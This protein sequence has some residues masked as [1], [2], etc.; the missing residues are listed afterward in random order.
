MSLGSGS[1]DQ[2]TANGE[3]AGGSRPS[4]NESGSVRPARDGDGP[5]SLNTYGI[6]P[7]TVPPFVLDS[8]FEKVATRGFTA[9]SK[10]KV[11]DYNRFKLRDPFLVAYDGKWGHFASNVGTN[12]AYANQQQMRVVDQSSSSSNNS[13][14]DKQSLSDDVSQAERE[15][16]RQEILKDLNSEWGG[17]KRLEELFNTPIAGNYEFKSSED[18]KAWT[19]YV[20]RI[21]QYYYGK[22]T[23]WDPSTNRTEL[24]Q[25][26]RASDGRRN[27]DW[28]EELN[29]DKLRF[30]RFKQRKLQ[31]WMPELNALLL[32]NQYLPLGLRIVVG[33]LSLISLGLAVRIYQNS[34]S[35]IQSIDSTIDQQP[36]TIMAICVNTIA[37]VYI[38]GIAHDEFSGKPLGLRNPFGKLRLILL[39]LLFIIFSSANLALAFN[40][41]YDKQWICTDDGQSNGHFY[42]YP[43][44]PYICK[45][46][47]ALS[48]FLFVMLFMWVVTFTISIVRVVEKVSSTS[49]R[50]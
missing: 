28:I 38:I 7:T 15:K 5:A 50:D 19:D 27:A 42:K 34:A 48:A 31:Q 37:I 32:D 20:T 22:N 45:K 24:D 44:V 49:P 23:A 9:G 8:Q 12:V 10:S 1:T 3:K 21:K 33:I 47:E 40:T 17:G 29:R 2:R 36:S 41:L 43:K 25:R 14:L 30:K 4:S 13:D 35:H 11:D 39:D 26:S 18:R 16:I 46:Q 6:Y